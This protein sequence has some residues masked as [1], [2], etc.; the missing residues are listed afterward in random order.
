MSDEL[1]DQLSDPKVFAETLRMLSLL[2]NHVTPAT[3]RLVIPDNVQVYRMNVLVMTPNG[4][5]VF[6]DYDIPMQLVLGRIIGYSTELDLLV[7]VK[8]T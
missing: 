7:M 4:K 3:K 6:R 2:A 8:E 1:A 5:S